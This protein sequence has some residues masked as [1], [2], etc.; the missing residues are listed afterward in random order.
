[1]KVEIDSDG[2]VRLTT[3]DGTVYWIWPSLDD[4]SEDCVYIALADSWLDDTGIIVGPDEHRNLC[5]RGA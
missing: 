5:K 4:G 2:D 1:M 3:R